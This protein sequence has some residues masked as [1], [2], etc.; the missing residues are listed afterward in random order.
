MHSDSRIEEFESKIY[1][2]VTEI[3]LDN[4]MTLTEEFSYR[5]VVFPYKTD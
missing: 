5:V 3:E 1:M 4:N 2:T